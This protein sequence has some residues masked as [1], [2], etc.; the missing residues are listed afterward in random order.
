MFLQMNNNR[1]KKELNL[2]E[3]LQPGMVLEQNFVEINVYPT[4]GEMEQIE[5]AIKSKNYGL[6]TKKIVD[7]GKAI[8][9][10]MLNDLYK[11]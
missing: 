10:L 9:N 4:K 1:S 2:Y 8:I 5:N 11:K 6:V 7:R 3:A